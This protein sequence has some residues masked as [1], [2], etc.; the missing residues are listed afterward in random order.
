MANT[1][2]KKI[3]FELWIAIVVSIVVGGVAAFITMRSLPVGVFLDAALLSAG[4]VLLV[5][6]AIIR[7]HRGEIEE[8]GLQVRHTFLGA[9]LILAATAGLLSLLASGFRPP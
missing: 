8:S 3:D 9:A 1:T 2:K 5:Y 7:H 6:A 4:V